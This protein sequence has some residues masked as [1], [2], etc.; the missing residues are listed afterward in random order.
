M[1]AGI[2]AIKRIRYCVPPA[3]L[4][5]IYRGIVQSHFDYCNAVWNSCSKS[6]SNKLQ[7]LQNRAA[8]VLTYSNYDTDANELIKILGF[9]FFNNF[10]FIDKTHIT[11]AKF[12]TKGKYITILQIGSKLH[13]DEKEQYSS[14][15]NSHNNVRPAN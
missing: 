14:C 10:T 9:F 5:S 13:K 11:V 8:R 3:N 4:H 15:S 1:A 6:L 12:N 2:E 7:R